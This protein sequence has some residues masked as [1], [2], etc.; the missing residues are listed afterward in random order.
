MYGLLGITVFWAGDLLL[1]AVW[2]P[3]STWSWILVPLTILLFLLWRSRSAFRADPVRP[4]EKAL[5]LTGLA[6]CVTLCRGLLICG[7]GGFIST[8]QFQGFLG[9]LPAILC[10]SAVAADGLDGWV[11][12]ARKEASPTGEALDREVDAMGTFV[13]AMLCYQYG[14]LPVFYLPVSG[15]YYLFSLAIWVRMKHGKL[16]HPLKPSRARRAI[17]TLQALSLILLLSPLPA[18]AEG[19]LFAAALALIVSAS[20]LKDWMVVVGVDWRTRLG[21]GSGLR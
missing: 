12:R 6:N 7:L 3:L 2:K 17:G 20:F 15:A 10:A 14:R 18:P 5:L 4:R 8:P 1:D 21:R 9:W 16:V 13:A 11:A 19:L